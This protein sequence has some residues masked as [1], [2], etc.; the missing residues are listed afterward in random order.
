MALLR[1]RWRVLF[2]AATLGASVGAGD[3]YATLGISR[4]A[5]VSTV[6]KAYRKLAKQY[7]PDHNK[8]DD[9]RERYH[10]IQ[11]AYNVLGDEEK[12]R[13]YDEWGARDERE[14]R[15]KQEARSRAFGGTGGLFHH[16]HGFYNRPTPIHSETQLLSEDNWA[17]Q[18]KEDSI[19]LVWYYS[20][21]SQ[22]CRRFQ[23]DWDE[24]AKGFEGVANF[25]RVNYD[26]DRS[27]PVRHGAST[28]PNVAMHYKGQMLHMNSERHLSPS[29]V[30]E[31]FF[32]HHY[33]DIEWV[34]SGSVDAFVQQYPHRPKVIYI[35]RS[36]EVYLGGIPLELVRLQLAYAD[37]LHFGIAEHSEAELKSRFDVAHWGGTTVVIRD[38]GRRVDRK[39][40]GLRPAM[41]MSK[42]LAERQYHTV[43]KLTPAHA[44]LCDGTDTA[45]MC[46]VLAFSPAV[47]EAEKDTYLQS[48]EKM[49]LP[50]GLRKTWV[51][52]A[53]QGKL[54][55]EFGVYTPPTEG[56]LLLLF[57]AR[58]ERY[59]SHTATY[60]SSKAFEEDALGMLRLRYVKASGDHA[61]RRG[62]SPPRLTLQADGEGQ[63]GTLF[64]VPYR[65][66]LAFLRG[67]TGAVPWQMLF[68]F[69]AV[70]F[71]YSRDNAPDPTA[72]SPDGREAASRRQYS[73]A[74]PSRPAST[75]PV[76]RRAPPKVKQ[77][78]SF[79]N[80]HLDMKGK[81]L[82]IF[83]VPE[84][85]AISTVMIPEAILN[86]PSVMLC[87]IPADH[88]RAAKWYDLFA[89]QQGCVSIVGL[90]G[91]SKKWTMIWNGA[92][93]ARVPTPHDIGNAYDK[94]VNGMASMRVVDTWPE[95]T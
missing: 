71:L 13:I 28:L 73:S 19:W 22:E 8:E 9:A 26:T 24:L 29:N 16:Q 43:Q 52:S 80:A 74:S 17:Y 42:W 33:H 34:T 65:R 87:Y 70:L 50:D 77:F 45:V 14:L 83:F 37:T 41:S 6:K 47:G 61:V 4:G 46:A 23:P 54:L 94:I 48:F 86:D 44:K 62:A 25:G 18:V 63:P 58:D 89:V 88:E 82:L 67:K 12:K 95:A 10:E 11:E 91:G 78:Q 85:S 3:L 30:I 56:V 27:L 53:A 31:F 7:H 1:W 40:G 39:S 35:L 57:S 84:P 93:E 81:W 59:A 55:S 60:S 79:R 90:R 92:N 5:D 72:P 64:G 75:T 76:A 32:E 68:F 51:H 15:M 36:K 2:V 66:V 49:N 69:V 38:G 20:D 21:R